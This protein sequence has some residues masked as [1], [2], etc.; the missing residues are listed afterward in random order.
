M[1]INVVRS[2]VTR[3]ASSTQAASA[4]RYS[5]S[6]AGEAS[7]DSARTRSRATG[8]RR[9]CATVSSAPRMPSTSV[10]MRSSEALNRRPSSSTMSPWLPAA[11]RPSSR[12][13]SAMPRA[14]SRSSRSGRSADRVSAIPPTRPAP[15]TVAKMTPNKSR[16]C[17]STRSRA[18][19]VRPTCIVVPSQS[20]RETISRVVFVAVD[21]TASQSSPARWG[22]SLS[23]CR[24]NVF[25]PGGTLIMSTSAPWPTRRTSTVSGPPDACSAAT[26]RESAASPPVS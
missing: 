19:V 12:P 2:A 1:S 3:S 5:V 25:H 16:T 17:A 22:M 21:G 7:A 11:T 20:G 8:V 13:V 18:T 24:S 14:A 4:S 15:S 23:W 26:A 6:L 9:S 10:S